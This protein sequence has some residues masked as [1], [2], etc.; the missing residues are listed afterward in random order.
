LVTDHGRRVYLRVGG[1][2]YDLSQE[3]LR[4]ALGQP[5]GPPGLGITIDRERVRFEFAADQQAIELT[6]KQLQRR[7]AKQLT[8]KL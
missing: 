3:T 2:F 8:D 1:R 7:I 6:A 5:E 4:T